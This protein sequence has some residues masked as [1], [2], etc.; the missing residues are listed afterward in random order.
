M[1]LCFDKSFA[2]LKLL[3]A[4]EEAEEAEEATLW[5]TSINRDEGIMSQQLDIWLSLYTAN[6]YILCC[7]SLIEYVHNVRA[8]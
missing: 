4:A 5:C 1:C 8:F 3:E 2:H 6:I 7:G